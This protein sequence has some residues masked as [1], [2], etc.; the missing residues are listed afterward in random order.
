MVA[1]FKRYAK[2][3][4]WIGDGCKGG[5][6]S[7]DKGC[8]LQKAAVADLNTKIEKSIEESK[9]QTASANNETP[10]VAADSVFNNYA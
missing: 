1:Y 2:S 10:K 8:R 4:L 5:D 6:S 7:A 9:I 3:T